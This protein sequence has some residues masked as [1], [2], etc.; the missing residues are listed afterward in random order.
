VTSRT[1]RS[2]SLRAVLLATTLTLV[3]VTALVVGVQA[4]RLMRRL[5]DTQV[6]TLLDIT[7]LAA[8]EEV[9][10]TGEQ[11]T[12]TA[13]LLAERPT[14]R[15]HIEAG[16]R[17]AELEFLDRFSRTGE[18]DGC[19]VLLPDGTVVG[20]DPALPWAE[21]ARD[22][23]A[24]RSVW[25]LLA[26]PGAAPPVMAAVHPVAGLTGPRVAAALRLDEDYAVEITRR[27][28][29]EVRIVS[30]ERAASETGGPQALLYARAIDEAAAGSMRVDAIAAFL[31]VQPLL[32][33]AGRVVALVETR[34]GTDS[35]DASV[36]QLA[37]A[38]AASAALV[39]GLASLAALLAGRRLVRPLEVLTG[40]SARIGE[41]DLDSPIPRVGG[42]ET[43]ALAATMEQMR[44]RLLRLTAELRRR[45]AEAEAVLTGIVERDGRRGGRPLLRR[46]APPRGS[47]RGSPLRRTLPDPRRALSRERAGDGAAGPARRREPDRGHHQRSPDDDRRGRRGAVPAVPGAA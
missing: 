3:C 23:H 30:R 36:R 2:P 40:A 22:E 46:R 33:S 39:A 31:N 41:G 1:E 5:A 24:T 20:G 26:G 42:A 28:G 34:L 38:L 9:Q 35:A 45:R 47:R 18:V 13:R 27:V 29:L 21:I 25:F 7:G 15:G 11:V 14:L 8:L 10:Q 16:D 44:D 17:R 6:R 4:V 43:A 19:A 12:T 32:D 37:R